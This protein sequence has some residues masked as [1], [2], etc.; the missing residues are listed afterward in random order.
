MRKL[1]QAWN[2][3]KTHK[4]RVLVH[5][6]IWVGFCLYALFLSGPLFAKFDIIPGEANLVQMPLPAETNNLQ[7]GLG[8]LIT[9]T[10]A[11]G[12]QG[13]AFI[14]NYSADDDHV[15]VVLKS[16]KTSYIFD[17]S[18]VWDNPITAEYGGPNLNLDWSGFTTTIPLRKIE[19]GNY[20]MGLCI[21]R[22]GITGL[23]FSNKVVI[24]SNTGVELT[25]L[26]AKTP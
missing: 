8:P 6:L 5:S 10:S 20:A 16:A 7:Y 17:S 3:I 25:D 18:A 9:S 23:Q 4:I 2:W 24:K 1:I 22:D 14:D 26:T 21:T 12:M 11:L 13:W 19:N 15:F